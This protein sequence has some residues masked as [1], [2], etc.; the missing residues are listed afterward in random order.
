MNRRTRALRLQVV[1][2]A[3]GLVA[4]VGL[5]ACSSGSHPAAGASGL[6]P[7]KAAFPPID[8]PIPFVVGANAGLFEKQGLDLKYDTSL[9]PTSVIASLL[10]GKLDVVVASWGALVTAA[11][12]HLPLVGIATTAVGGTSLQNDDER[13]VAPPSSPVKT[14]ADLAGRSV[15]VNTLGS[16]SQL[17]VEVDAKKAG[18]D[19]STVKLIPIPFPDMGAALRA[20]RVDAALVG[21]PF[22]TLLAKQGEQFTT[23]AGGHSALMPR[24]QLGAVIV[25]RAFYEQHQDVVAKIKRA[26]QDSTELAQ[27]N[28]Q[29]VRDLLPSFSKLPPPVA[30]DVQLPEFTSMIDPADIQKQ[31]DL[32]Y[33]YGIIKNQ[34]T[35]NPYIG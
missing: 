11:S 4:A 31:A 33:E 22:L 28:P 27:R 12:A 2:M 17:E 34:V 32:L 19:P 10:S 26:T 30:Q 16:L 25:T 24:L 7:V 14:P 1:A 5:S 8:L 6:V 3:L 18:L 21:E 20:G 15:A 9:P 29:A 13:L 35:M 23:V